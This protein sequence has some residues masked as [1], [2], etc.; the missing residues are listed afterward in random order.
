MVFSNL[1]VCTNHS[2][3]LQ[4]GYRSK[5]QFKIVF[6]QPCLSN[7]SRVIQFDDT[8]TR[9]ERKRTYNLSVIRNIW[10]I[11]IKNRPN[12]YIPEE[13]VAVNDQPTPNIS[14]KPAKCVKKDLCVFVTVK[15][16]T[17]SNW[18]LTQ[19]RKNMHHQGMHVVW[20]PS[21]KAEVIISY[22]KM[23]LFRCYKNNIIKIST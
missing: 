12:L 22:V 21:A 15:H 4:K 9:H 13:N 18:K 17:P 2:E 8:T 7:Y 11:R 3:K 14:S 1:P 6:E 5:T 23:F 19:E 20:I 10:E 16:L